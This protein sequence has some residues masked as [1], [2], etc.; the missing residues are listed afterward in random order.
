MDPIAQEMAKRHIISKRSYL[1][2]T[3]VA[4]RDCHV[5][6]H[7]CVVDGSNLVIEGD[8]NLIRAGDYAVF[9]HGNQ[10]WKGGEKIRVR[11]EASRA[12]VGWPFP[13]AKIFPDLPP[14]QPIA[15]SSSFRT[16]FGNG[17]LGT[18][19]TAISTH[20][21]SGD[22]MV[23]G[24][25]IG[26]VPLMLND[27]E[28]GEERAKEKFAQPTEEEKK[29]FGTD[30]SGIRGMATVKGK[31]KTCTFCLEN[32]P[33]TVMTGCGHKCL[34]PDCANLMAKEAGNA[35]VKCPVCKVASS[36]IIRVY[37]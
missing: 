22:M 34:C 8:G 29:K 7:H 12:G 28:V 21:T 36:S 4:D 24:V 10:V 37:E 17:F 16:G 14:I 27:V 5:V 32:E 30:V 19:M 35:K 13:E 9:G 3:T 6:C 31:E 2:W 1:P 18:L 26:G 33:S 11:E 15:T 23:Y 20:A 25:P